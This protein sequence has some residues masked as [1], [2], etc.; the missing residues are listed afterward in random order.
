MTLLV[1][2]VLTPLVPATALYLFARSRPTSWLEWFLNFI[3][4]GAVIEVF[5]VIGTWVFLSYYLRYA[6]LVV[7]L[8]IAVTQFGRLR[9]G[10]VASRVGASR[11]IVTRTVGALIAVWIAVLAYMGHMAPADT[12]DLS[13]PLAGGKYCVIQGGSNFVTN[14]FHNFVDSEHS[15]DFVKIN[16]I[17][18]RASGIVP[19]DVRK[20]QIYG[21][22]V[23]SPCDGVVHTVVDT[24]LDNAPPRANAIEPLGNHVMIVDD[25][26]QIILAHLK[27]GS[28]G[29]S[30]GDSVLRGEPI[31]RVG[32]SGYSNEPHLHLQALRLGGPD[33]LPQ[34][35]GIT[36]AG[37]FVAI[38]DIVT[39][40]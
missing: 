31:G 33:N 8:V 21:E 22:M 28:V 15:L 17:G 3:I 30:L 12:V 23:Y 35:V 24:V 34:P 27:E 37:R 38:N 11:R 4:T 20:Y 26:I 19:R 40:R 2:A 1:I 25:G 18:N 13:F 39:Q 6:F 14:P 16:R 7:F 9:R 10:R 5:H 29:V 36:F 32:N